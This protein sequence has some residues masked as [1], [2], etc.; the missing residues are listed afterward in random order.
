MDVRHLNP[1][2]KRYGGYIVEALNE[3]G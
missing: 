1:P 3:F 2:K